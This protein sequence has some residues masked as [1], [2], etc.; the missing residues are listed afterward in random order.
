MRSISFRALRRSY[1]RPNS[2][3][4]QE[5][6]LSPGL[7]RS[8][9]STTAIQVSS[10]ILL[11]WA[12]I[13]PYPETTTPSPFYSSMLLAWSITEVIRYSYFFQNLRSGVPAWLTWLRYNTFFILYPVGIA[14][15]CMMIWKGREQSDEP[16]VKWALLSV[17]ATYV[18]GSWIMYT[19]MMKQRRKINKGKAVERSRAPT[20]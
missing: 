15:E 7:V 20:M 14:S 16:W 18:P 11:V 12:I 3:S 1:P 19:H 2:N 5:L 10:R 17:L 8:P 4:R 9:I 6:N 13:H